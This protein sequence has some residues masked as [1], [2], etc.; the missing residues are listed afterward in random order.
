MSATDVTA[1]WLPTPSGS[2]ARRTWPRWARWSWW[3]LR[4]PTLPTTV[5]AAVALGVTAGPVVVALV[6]AVVTGL[7][8]VW[9]R[10]HPSS[11]DA[12]AGRLLRGWWRSAWTYGVR[13][14]AGMMFAGLGGR[15][16]GAEWVPRVVRVRSGRWADRVTVRMVVGQQPADWERR[17]DALAHA[18]GARSCLVRPRPGRPGYLDLRIGRQD[19]L[20]QVVPA[21]PIPGADAVDLDGVPVGVTQDGAPWRLA[22]AG[23]AHTLVAGETG[24]GKSSVIWSLLRGLAPAIEAGWV[25]VWACD[26]KGGMELA[27]GAPLFSRLAYRPEAMVELLEHAAAWMEAR[28]DRLRG[29]TRVHTPSVEEPALV[30]LVDELAHLTAYGPDPALRRRAIAA[31]ALLLSAGRAPAVTVVG[32]L[33]DPRKDV[34]SIRDLFPV[35]VAL[36]MVEA[37]QTKLVLGDGAHDRGAACELIPR[38]LPGVGYVLLDGDHYPT[39]VRSAWVS[40]DDIAATAAHHCAPGRVDDDDGQAVDDGPAVVEV[41]GQAAN[42][43]RLATGANGTTRP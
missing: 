12:T 39:R 29:V 3:L 32:A 10:R 15:L 41:D 23:G 2:L 21:L 13:W 38:A 22:L 20:A 37:Q 40:D 26:P 6:L 35:R 9:A 31:L 5:A 19:P 7:L 14:R 34:L 18:F 11:W 30:V 8:V 17:S 28:C 16:D 25:Q 42:V 4:H 27:P 1:G 33:Q 36:R 43:V 24:A